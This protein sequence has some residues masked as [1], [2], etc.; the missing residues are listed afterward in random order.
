MPASAQPREVRPYPS[1]TSTTRTYR[2][3]CGLTLG[4]CTYYCGHTAGVQG[5]SI[6]RPSFRTSSNVLVFA[7]SYD[8]CTVFV[9]PRAASRSSASAVAAWHAR[10]PRRPDDPRLCLASLPLPPHLT[11][12]RYSASLQVATRYIH[13]SATPAICTRA[14]NFDADRPPTDASPPSLTV[15]LGSIPPVSERSCHPR[16][17]QDRA[18]SVHGQIHVHGSIPRLCPSNLLR[19]SPGTRSRCVLTT[20]DS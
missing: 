2:P 19:R 8:V 6:L 9:S 18:P 12:S 14:R 3:A 4:S 20:A 16:T 7:T 5:A 15:T 10:T 11:F 17:S 13:R 1:V